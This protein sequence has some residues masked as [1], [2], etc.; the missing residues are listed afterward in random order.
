MQR[1][2]NKIKDIVSQIPTC[3]NLIKIYDKLNLKRTL[4]SLQ[5]NEDRLNTILD[6]SPLVRNR[7][8]LMRLRKTI[9]NNN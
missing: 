5:V 4:S 9:K 3:E 6:C 8:T 1:S 2:W 7:L